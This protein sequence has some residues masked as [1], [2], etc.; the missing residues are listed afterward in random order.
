MNYDNLYYLI[1]DS[2]EQPMIDD[3]LDINEAHG[4]NEWS[5]E[6]LDKIN[7]DHPVYFLTPE[8]L[9]EDLTH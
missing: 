7:I 8:A 1:Y 4:M 3:D 2:G 6:C 5:F 9:S